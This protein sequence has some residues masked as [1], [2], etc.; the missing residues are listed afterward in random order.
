M[1]LVASD[2]A[3]A[4]WPSP[5]GPEDQLG[6]LNHITDATRAQA[7]RLVRSGRLYDLG[8]VL[9]E[10][11]PAFP[12][13]YFRQTLVTTAHHSNRGG[14]GANRVNWITEQVA[15]TQQLGTHL[16]ALC[17]L[18][19]GDRGY[20][21]WSVGELA[22]AG[23]ATRLGVETVPQIVTRGWLVDVAPL[24]PGEVIGVPDIDPA[25]GDA[26]LFHTGWGEHWYDA[27]A[28]L[29]G[30]PGPGMELARWLVQRGVAL[31]GCDTWSYGPVPAEDPE[32]P[33]EVPQFLSTHHGVFIV[34]NL[35]TS[36]LARDGVREFA[37]IL[38]HPKLR[39]ASG[40]WTSPVALV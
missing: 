20:N 17:H 31:T 27:D 38:T 16:D 21:G 40:A 34:E 3:T 15:G 26:V 1:V 23:G 33:F 2:E 19:I 37:L 9:D 13:R 14:L 35:D 30:E 7:L 29:S 32:R 25:P 39:G 28:Y 36:E 12:G 24:D 10:N 6:M 4:W 5:F 18:Q 11:T 8:R 22:G